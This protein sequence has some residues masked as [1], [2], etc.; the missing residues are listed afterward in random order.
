MELRRKNRKILVVIT[1]YV[2]QSTYREPDNGSNGQEIPHILEPKA[3][4]PCSQ[5][6]VTGPHLVPV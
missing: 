5:I 2:Q 4:L 1:N 6:P 3:S